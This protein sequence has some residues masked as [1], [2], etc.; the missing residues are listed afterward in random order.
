MVCDEEALSIP[1]STVNVLS[2]LGASPIWL[3]T[4]CG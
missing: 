4:G 3:L 1:S 2:I